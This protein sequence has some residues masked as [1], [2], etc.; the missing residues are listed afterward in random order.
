VRLLILGGTG[1]LSGHVAAEALR[2]GHA[3][4]CLARGK[5]GTVPPG[6]TFVRADRSV[7]HAY[8]TVAGEQWD[9]TVD[10]SSNP[11][12]VGEASAALAGRTSWYAYVSSASVYADD[13]VPGQNEDAKL[14]PPI[15]DGDAANP[16]LYGSHKVACERHVVQTFGAA[17]ALVVRPGLIGGPGDRSDRSGY[18]PLRFA[19]PAAPD[20]RV[21]VPDEPDLAM[22]VIDVRDLAA[23]IVAAAETKIGGIF[24]ALGESFPLSRHLEIAREVAGHNG[25]LVKASSAWLQAHGV[26]PWMGERSLPL[27]LPLPEYAGFGARDDRAARARGLQ[28]RPLAQTLSDTLAWERTRDA[29][30]PRRA[31]LTSVDELALLEELSR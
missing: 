11:R 30:R 3:V 10:V 25:P 28:N 7:P 24:T 8:D 23:W 15:E 20:G 29:T 6:A 27:W 13:T 2:R 9:A 4:T 5:A 14:L 1:W 31:G 19:H 21:L 16:E 22:E 26:E 18:W 12:Y 17:R